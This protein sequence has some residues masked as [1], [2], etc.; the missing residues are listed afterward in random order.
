MGDHGLLVFKPDH[1]G[2]RPLVVRHKR[3]RVPVPMEEVLRRFEDDDASCY[4]DCGCDACGA[5]FVDSV[6][7]GK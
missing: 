6:Q 4:C 5:E 1:P 7:E 3:R 2:G